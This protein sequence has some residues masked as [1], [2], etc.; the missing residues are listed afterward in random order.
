MHVLH[1]IENLRC[2]WTKGARTP[3][4]TGHAF[5]Y[6][7]QLAWVM[8]VSLAT[9]KRTRASRT[10]CFAFTKPSRIAAVTIHSVPESA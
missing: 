7:S 6:T 8:M 9:V 10:H 4:A 2:I 3:T 5:R 1:R